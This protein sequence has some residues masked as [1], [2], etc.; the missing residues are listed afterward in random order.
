MKEHSSNQK[1]TVSKANANQPFFQKNSEQELFFKPKDGENSFFNKRASFFPLPLD[2]N[3]TPVQRK[4]N[5]DLP[6]KIQT[7]MENSFGQDFSNVNI[8]RSSQ[9]AVDLNALAFTKGDSI[10]FAPGKFNP[11][12]KQGRNLIGHEFTHVVQQKNSGVNPTTVMRK[13]LNLNDDRRLEE[14]ADNFG[15]KAVM[16]ENIPQYQS[17]NLSLDDHPTVT[18]AKSNVIQRFY[19]PI[20]ASAPAHS[21]DISEFINLVE[22]EEQKY[23]EEE[24]ANTSLMITRIRKIFYGSEGWDDHLIRG[25][26]DISS[27]YGEPRE[28][29][30]SRTEVEVPGPMNDFDMVDT[31][32]YP[33]DPTTGQRPEIYRNQEVRLPDGNFID[34]GHVFAGLDAYNHRHAASVPIFS[35]ISIDNLGGVTWVGDLGSALAEAQIHYVNH[36]SLSNAQVQDIVNEYASS[37]DM[38]GN[39]DAYVIAENYQIAD[40]CPPPTMNRNPGSTTCTPP[41]LKVSEILRHYYLGEGQTEYQSHRYQTFAESIGLRG[42]DGSTW[43]NIDERIE[44]FTDQVNDA[45]ALYIGAGSR[46]WN[47]LGWGGA[48]L[49]MSMN[50]GAESFVRAFF[51]ALKIRL[52]AESNN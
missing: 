14:E 27:P 36:D 21:I 13:G 51:N 25:V 6:E 31:E 32:T 46:S 52:I 50:E 42:W 11:S 49:G 4:K 30:R 37:Q 17:S 39:I 16:G 29:E 24:Q 23:S 33:V 43:S 48:I 3:S 1:K 7:K 18:Q 28:R 5:K 34:M 35:A 12:T 41:P 40:R 19:Q 38:L 20:E 44:Y 8:Q 2:F 22:A 9:E 26:E 15:K 47:P 45:A 10:H